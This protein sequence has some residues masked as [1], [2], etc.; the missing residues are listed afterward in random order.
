M[1][2]KVTSTSGCRQRSCDI[3]T[4][5][6]SHASRT[7]HHFPLHLPSSNEAVQSNARETE[8]KR[9]VLDRANIFL[10]TGL[11]YFMENHRRHIL[12]L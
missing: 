3:Q 8:N 6:S 2:L 1:D 5:G 12:K 9:T 4:S 10:I 11:G 7:S